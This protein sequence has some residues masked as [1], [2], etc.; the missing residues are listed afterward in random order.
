[1][2]FH[3]H[4]HACKDSKCSQCINGT[5]YCKHWKTHCALYPGLHTPAFASLVSD[6]LSDRIASF[7]ELLWPQF[8]ITLQYPCLHTASN[9]K[10]EQELQKWGAMADVLWRRVKLPRVCERS[11]RGGH[12][13]LHF[14]LGNVLW[15]WR[16]GHKQ[17]LSSDY[18]PFC[19]TVLKVLSCHTQKWHMDYT[20]VPTPR[21]AFCLLFARG[22]RPETRLRPVY[23][24]TFAL[25][26][27]MGQ[28]LSIINCLQGQEQLWTRG[29]WEH[30]HHSVHGVSTNF[31]I[32]PA[33]WLHSLHEITVPIPRSPQRSW[34]GLVL[35]ETRPT[36]WVILYNI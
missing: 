2:K 36:Q 16:G 30:V 29:C 25:P 7:P 4:N 5:F 34:W 26:Q 10:L 3:S 23:W 8:V 21:P 6:W 20:L 33:T 18:Q 28:M 12:Q 24:L 22:E 14:K 35:A 11:E 17:T 32:K 1:M 15:R 9:Q 13:S 31:W 19:F 27:A